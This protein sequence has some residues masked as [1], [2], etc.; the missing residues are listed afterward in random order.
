MSKK[1]YD[2]EP[3]YY[4]RRC[5]SLKVKQIAGSSSPDDL[6]CDD[7]GSVSIGYIVI[8]KWLELQ[9]RVREARLSNE[10]R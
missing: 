9:K 4:C 8:D 5:L 7:C 2:E 10:R 3:V 1:E 6:Y